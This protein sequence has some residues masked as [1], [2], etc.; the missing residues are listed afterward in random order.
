[1]KK[2]IALILFLF[3]A[4][5][6]FAQQKEY[7]APFTTLDVDAPIRLTLIKIKEH[8]APYI[9]YDTKGAEDSKFTFEVKN[10]KFK[11]RE[12]YD[13]NRKSVTDVTI[14]FTSLT[15]IS[16]SRADVTVEGVLTSQLLDI[17]VSHN[18]HFSAE[19]DVL[20]I[21]VNASGKSRIELGG[22]TQ[23]HT[24]DI[25]SAQYNA[26]HME[27]TSTIVESSHNGVA[28]VNAN[29]RLELRTATGGKIY[30]YSQPVIF[31]SVITAF[32]GEIALAK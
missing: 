9:I 20:D 14:G 32:G 11:V 17:Y 27:S 21:M 23:Y 18:A 26:H 6:L 7:L 12:R 24:A 28:R 8:E 16:I 4:T 25:T 2:F 19:V 30:Y 22:K 13:S 1:M 10:K 5:T 29:E 3:T 31:R 15:D